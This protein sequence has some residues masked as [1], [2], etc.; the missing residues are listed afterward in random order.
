MFRCLIDS[1]KQGIDFI[2][3][4]KYPTIHRYTKVYTRT[5]NSYL[6]FQINMISKIVKEMGHGDINSDLFVPKIK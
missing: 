3:N 6:S 5:S 4:K 1:S 2:F